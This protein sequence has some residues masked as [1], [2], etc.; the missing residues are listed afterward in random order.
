M[1]EEKNLKLHIEE[2]TIASIQTALRQGEITCKELV[3]TYMDRIARMDKSGPHLNSIIELN[4][5]AIHIA[6]VL[7]R[8]GIPWVKE[9]PCMAYQCLLRII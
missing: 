2:A 1:S 6:D 3:I 8:K 9:V 7:I 5:E 4:P